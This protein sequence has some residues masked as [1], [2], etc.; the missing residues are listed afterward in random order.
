MVS[1]W[2]SH[3]FQFEVQ[4]VFSYLLKNLFHMVA[5]FSQVPGEDEI[6]DVHNLYIC[7]VHFGFHHFLSFFRKNINKIK[8]LRWGS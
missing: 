1:R 5:M 3:F 2:N 8:K 6:V 4:M 7:D